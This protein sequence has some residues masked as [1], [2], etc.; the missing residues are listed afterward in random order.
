MKI[1]KENTNIDENE[2]ITNLSGYLVEV[3]AVTLVVV[4]R[5]GL[6]VVVEH[7]GFVAQSPESA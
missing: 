6:R 4:G 7:D 3:E 5:N 2:Q 1:N